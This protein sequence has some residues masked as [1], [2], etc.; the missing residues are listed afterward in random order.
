MSRATATPAV[1]G[2]FLLLAAA[3]AAHGPDTTVSQG[4]AVIVT[5]IYEDGSPMAFEVCEVLPPG[6]R[7]PFLV[8]RTDRL[9]RVA[10]APDRLGEWRVRVTSEDGHGVEVPVAV[11]ESMIASAKASAHGG[12]IWKLVTGVSVL[13]GVFGLL[14]LATQRRQA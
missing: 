9:G 1:V 3:A 6:D 8:G 13:F 5:A 2:A 7:P 10:F 12:R 11:D 4:A 14:N